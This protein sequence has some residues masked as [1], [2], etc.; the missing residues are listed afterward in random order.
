M[1]KMEVYLSG[2]TTDQLNACQPERVVPVIERI[3]SAL[4]DMHGHLKRW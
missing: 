1:V 4:A 2:I 3:Q